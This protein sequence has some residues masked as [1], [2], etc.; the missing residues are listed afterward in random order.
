MFYIR[1]WT[2]APLTSLAANNDLSLF[3]SLMKFNFEP[4]S[5]MKE[6]MLNKMFLHLWYLSEELSFFTLFCPTIENAVKDKCSRAM[7]KFEPS[8]R[9]GKLITPNAITTTMTLPDLF[10]PRSYLLADLVNESVDFLK[11]PASSW[12]TDASYC[13]LAKIIFNIP[14]VN[15]AAERAIL[16]AKTFHN[17]L[18]DKHDQKSCLYTTVPRTRKLLGKRRKVDVMSN[19]I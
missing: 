3:K 16:L 1:Q 15:D 12:E 7:K 14:S 17:K 6:A 13:R 9:V 19:D 8:L 5:Q 2:E 11:H 4:M 10:G 18:T